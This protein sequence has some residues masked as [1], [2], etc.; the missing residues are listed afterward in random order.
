MGTI[1]EPQQTSSHWLARSCYAMR[2]VARPRSFPHLIYPYQGLPLRS[3]LTQVIYFY[4]IADPLQYAEVSWLISHVIG[5]DQ[6]GAYP[7]LPRIQ[8]HG[9]GSRHHTLNTN[10]HDVKW[11]ARYREEGEAEERPQPITP[12][13]PASNV[14]TNNQAPSVTP[15]HVE[16]QT[17]DEA[18][19]MAN[20]SRL[21]P[22]MRRRMRELRLQGV[23][24]RLN[25]LSEDV[26]E[27]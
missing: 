10:I 17:V 13:N 11:R 26:D 5:S 27:E 14:T 25:Y 4:L 16:V 1:S 2:H 24:T 9:N 22:L 23:A 15:M 21:E 20:Y 3:V 18:F 6:E 7:I 19:V 8:N 12:L